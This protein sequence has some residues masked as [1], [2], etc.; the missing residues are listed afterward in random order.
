MEII[1]TDIGDDKIDP[2]E[3]FIDAWSEGCIKKIKELSPDIIIADMLST[4]AFNAADEFKI[5]VV[6][7]IPG[8][9]YSLYQGFGLEKFPNLKVAK[10]SFGRVVVGQ[11][12]MA[13]ITKMALDHYL[14]FGD[15]SKQCRK[16]WNYR[17]VMYQSFWGFETA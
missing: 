4:P 17:T 13:W 9:P 5:P 15:K 11:S 2:K 10:S 8:G 7:N 6:L 1:M 16:M 12:V 14:V 3:K